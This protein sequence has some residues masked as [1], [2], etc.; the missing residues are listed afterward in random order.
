[1]YGIDDYGTY[2]RWLNAGKLVADEVTSTVSI[3]LA[4]DLLAANLLIGGA[5][6]ESFRTGTYRLVTH[7]RTD[8]IAATDDRTR[9]SILTLEQTIFTAYTSVLLPAVYIGPTT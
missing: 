3:L 1:M 8:G 5:A 6:K 9:T 7:G 2:D 4:L